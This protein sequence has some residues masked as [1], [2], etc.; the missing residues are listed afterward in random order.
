MPDA[1]VT[2]ALD[3]IRER[4]EVAA[5]PGPDLHPAR[6]SSRRSASDQLALAD[7]PRLLAV[8]DAVLALHHSMPGSI[9][10]AKCAECTYKWPCPTVEAVSA[11][12][13]GEGSTD[14]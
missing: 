1:D 2:A 5:D 10:V 13:L 4:Y 7:V 9:L 12:L 3:G 8:A 6:A 11:A 14:G